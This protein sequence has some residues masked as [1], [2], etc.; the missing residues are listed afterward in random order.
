L[1]LKMVELESFDRNATKKLV[2]EVTEAQRLANVDVK[3]NLVTKNNKGNK[4]KDSV[5]LQAIR[6]MDYENKRVA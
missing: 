5:A 3:E 1:C 2:N 4:G 6:S